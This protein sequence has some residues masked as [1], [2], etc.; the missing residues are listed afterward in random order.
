MENKQ[1]SKQTKSILKLLVPSY[2][3]LVVLMNVSR[4]YQM[5]KIKLYDVINVA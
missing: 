2:T 1:I 5:I 3:L 4:V